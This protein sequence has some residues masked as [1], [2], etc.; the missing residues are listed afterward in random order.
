MNIIQADQKFRDVAAK[1]ARERLI[2]KSAPRET[3]ACGQDKNLAKCVNLAHR[4]NGTKF[5][6]A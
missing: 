4:L 3:C 2:E 5:V 1:I 6:S